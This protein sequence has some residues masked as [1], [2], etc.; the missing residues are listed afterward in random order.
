MP[1]WTQLIAW[2]R[3]SLRL[4][5]ATAVVLTVLAALLAQG[6]YFDAYLR[7]SFHALAAQRVQQAFERVQAQI[8]GIEQ[9]LLGGV[10][11]VRNDEP[12]L[13][14]VAL[15]NRY[16]DKANYNP[17]LID[18]E[19]KTLAEG[20]LSRVRLLP[21]DLVV[22][23][24]QDDELI[25][26]VRRDAAD[27]ELGLISYLN[28]QPLVLTRKDKV[29][30]YQTGQ[31]PPDKQLSL[32]H[33]A[34]YA[35]EQA[36]RAPLVT[37][38]RLG[39]DLLIESHYTLTDRQ[40]GLTLVHVEMAQRVDAALMQLLSRDLDLQVS[41]SFDPADK[42]SALPLAAKLPTQPLSERDASHSY[43]SVRRL[44]TLDGDA[45]IQ[46]TLD[47][48][49]QEELVAAQR[50]RALALTLAVGVLV[51]WLARLWMQG[52]LVEPLR[53]L[54]LQVKRVRS[55]DY[56]VQ[57]P[58]RTGDEIESISLSL[59]T[60]ALAV[61][62]REARLQQARNE[63]E[64]LSLHDSLTGL[65][66]RRCMGQKLDAAVARGASD[67]TSFALLFIDLD[68]FKLVNDTL[69]HAVGDQL[70]QQIGQ[71][72]LAHTRPSDTLARIGGDEFNLLITPLHDPSE[73]QALLERYLHLFDHP[74]PCASST[75]SITASIG[76]AVYPS[77]GRD[78][79][80][81]L[82][83]ADLAVYQAKDS[84]RARYCLYS[85]EL[86][87]R[88]ERR[89]QIIH[90]LDLAIEAGDQFHLVYQPKVS[91][92][93]G[94]VVAAEALIRWQSPQWGLVSP[95]QFIPLAEETGQIAALAGC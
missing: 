83:H 62:E 84:G 34:S 45:Y 63:Q 27:F 21:I 5:L 14:S 49:R 95:A 20:L 67:G 36:Q 78:A 7:Q 38:S 55:A 32:R 8:S 42:A 54:M 56:S 31:L 33:Q 76:V 60:L 24:G 13:A 2:L 93:S 26:W 23:Y 9:R 79:S 48:S 89:N 57:A 25:A 1:R 86:S 11:F 61:A 92:R 43:Q 64:F 37:R 81:L 16:Q 73:L 59:G 65:P 4:K 35:L 28:G 29:A 74:Y 51:L 19:K 90:A 80:S 94:A 53:A 58:V 46:I 85:D 41:L 88:A 6:L 50:L 72:M 30:E 3:A 18:E 70:L 66:N 82:K 77:D 44:N 47:K 91:V 68:Q 71:R 12:M 40:R 10:D 39:A 15:I 17:F 52:A 22:L 87:Q 75:L 69:G